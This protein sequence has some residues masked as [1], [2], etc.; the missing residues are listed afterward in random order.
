MLV[1]LEGDLFVNVAEVMRWEGNW[2]ETGARWQGGSGFSNQLYWLF[3]RQFIAIGQA[4]YGMASTKSLMSFAVYPDD[5]T[6]YNYAINEYLNN[7]CAGIYSI[8][9]PKIGQNFESGRDQ[10]KSFTRSCC[11]S[12]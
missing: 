7:P 6:L 9:D 2:T 11:S 3:S 8:S 4:N 12:R 10:G 1:G 5:V